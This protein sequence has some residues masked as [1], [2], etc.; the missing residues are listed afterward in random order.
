M[1]GRISP[2]LDA[3]RRSRL[4][5]YGKSCGV[6]S[7]CEPPLG[8]LFQART[9]YAHCTDSQCLT[10]AQCPEGQV[11][12][13]LAT[14]EDGPLVRFCVALGMRQEGEGC[15]KVPG[16]K[17]YA[18]A[19]GLVCGGR[20][21]W[22]SRPCRPGIA[23]QCPEG[24]F[25][26]DTLPEPVCL[27]TCEQRACPTGQHCVRFQE[28]A[29]VCAHVYGP[30]CQQ[31]PCPEGRE[32]RA[33]R[34]SL[35]PGKVWMECVERCGEG[36]PPCGEGKVCDAWHCVPPCDPLGPEVCNEGY[37]CDRRTESRPF[38]CQPDYWRDMAY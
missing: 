35:H 30:H 20:D 12:R 5:T 9:G 7:E 23:A 6:S 17:G 32:C 18:C 22:C 19:A 34:E 4:M 28:G 2:V 37:Y 10:D 38:S 11:C 14:D 26:A 25:C 36:F 29:S 1:E 8:C 33:H 13:T 24:F 31:S 27:P 21:G 16:D 15:L 3:E